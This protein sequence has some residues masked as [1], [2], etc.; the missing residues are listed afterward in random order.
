MGNT[1]AGTGSGNGKVNEG[2][3]GMLCVGLSAEVCGRPNLP[4]LW[5]RKAGV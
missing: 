2:M 5:T 4:N 1:L 3:S